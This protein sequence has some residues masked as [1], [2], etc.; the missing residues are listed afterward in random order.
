MRYLLHPKYGPSGYTCFALTGQLE[1]SKSSQA[2]PHI[3]SILLI[4]CRFPPS[5]L[6]QQLI[7]DIMVFHQSVIFISQWPQSVSG[8][9]LSLVFI[10]LWFSWNIQSLLDI[11]KWLLSSHQSMVFIEQLVFSDINLMAFGFQK[12]LL[13]RWGFIKRQVIGN[14]QNLSIIVFQYSSQQCS[15]TTIKL[16]KLSTFSKCQ[17]FQTSDSNSLLFLLDIF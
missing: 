3:E 15:S 10:S 6:S 8:F 11:F 7:H 5:Y 17:T 16:H 4:I 2:N 13:S 1:I 9:H 14:Y 12:Y